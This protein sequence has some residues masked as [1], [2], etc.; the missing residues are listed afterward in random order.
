MAKRPPLHAPTTP[1]LAELNAQALAGDDD[2]LRL[3]AERASASCDTVTDFLDRFV[4]SEDITVVFDRYCDAFQ[5]QRSKA[6][7]DTLELPTVEQSNLNKGW[8]G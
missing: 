2:A 4:P 6:L 1:S 7:L 3:L 5:R 8:S